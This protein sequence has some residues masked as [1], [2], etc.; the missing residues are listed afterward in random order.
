MD[1]KMIG[2]GFFFIASFLYA[3]KYISAA[4]LGIGFNNFQS[5]TYD[6]MLDAIG[7]PLSNLS[8][9]ASIIG[10]IFFYLEFKN[11]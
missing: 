2:L 11:N 6:I 7:N 5:E 9:I 1:N 4:L 10:V 8:I 3:T